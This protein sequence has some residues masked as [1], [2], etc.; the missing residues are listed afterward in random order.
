MNKLSLLKFII[1][2]TIIAVTTLTF[3]FTI[4]KELGINYFLSKLNNSDIN[5]KYSSSK[6][7]WIGVDFYNV[8]VFHIKNPY[9]LKLNKVSITCNINFDFLNS[10][11]I[12]SELY[13]GILEVAHNKDINAELKNINLSEI[14][15]LKNHSI[16]NG[17]LNITPIIISSELNNFQLSANIN[18]ANFVK[19]K[20]SVL[21]STVTNLPLPIRIEPIK[22]SKLNGKLSALNNVWDLSDITAETSYGNIKS[23]TIK[24]K[25]NIIESSK[26]IISLNQDGVDILKPILQFFCSD[27]SV[28][29]NYNLEFKNNQFRCGVAS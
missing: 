9:E 22:I 28:N 8:E 6:L 27:L 5:I 21:S 12:E 15:F 25:N 20:A 26:S 11:K 24:I 17:L 4:I 1:P 13:G 7:K 3:D 29:T 19:T 14:E 23:S 2:I 18:I 16:E 10:C